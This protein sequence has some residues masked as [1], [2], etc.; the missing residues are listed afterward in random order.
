MSEQNCI[1][2]KIANREINSNL[3]IETE[4]YVAFNDL[5]PQA[6]AHALVIPKKHC[7]SLNEMDNAEL[8]GKLLI[9]ARK[10]AEKL[11]IKDG[12]RV[13]INTG[14]E[15]GQ[16]VFHIHV[17]VLGGRPMKWPPG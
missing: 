3:I 11:N 5:S 7:A 2:C 8:L 16:T 13:V 4:D 15:A 10:T 14:A 6:P 9:G 12:Y 17:H 1:F